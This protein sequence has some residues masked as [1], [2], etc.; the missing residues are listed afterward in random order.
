MTIM[1]TCLGAIGTG[2]D[3]VGLE[4]RALEEDLV[5]VERLVDGGEDALRDG[6]AGLDVVAAVGEDLG[7]DDGHE[8]ELLA[9]ERVPREALGVLPDGELGGLRG[10]DLEHGAPL[11]EA[12]AGLVVLGA[13]RAQGV[14]ALRG[15]LAVGARDLDG[16]LVDLDPRDGAAGADHV[17]ERRPVGG[18]LVQRLLEEDDP[19]EVVEHAGRR[20]EQLAERLPVR[21]H[22][23][24]VDAGQALADGAR[25]L[26]GRQDALARR[27]QVLGGLDQLICARAR[28]IY[29]TV[30]TLPAIELCIY[31]LP[32][33]QHCFIL[34][35]SDSQVNTASYCFFLFTNTVY[36][37]L[38]ASAVER[39]GSG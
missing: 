19:G 39:A 31:I 33:V 32:T 11:G 5:V 24:E 20:E 2:G 1:A 17:H 18:L 29:C 10:A 6:G 15:G 3:H 25:R 14:E 21:L 26:V 23:L 22:V 28:I 7:L 12:R 13:A 16:A 37:C 34:F 38:Y 9:D 30:C 35:P 8:P 27:C 4:E 36:H